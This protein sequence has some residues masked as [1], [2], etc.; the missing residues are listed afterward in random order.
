MSQTSFPS[1]LF[2]NSFMSLLPSSVSLSRKVPSTP[3]PTYPLGK[4]LDIL[5]P[6]AKGSYVTLM[7]SE[8]IVREEG[9][10]GVLK[11]DKSDIPDEQKLDMA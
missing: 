5:R 3:S 11:Y 8:L 1:N 2:F 7:Q 10:H 4:S 9:H 6:S